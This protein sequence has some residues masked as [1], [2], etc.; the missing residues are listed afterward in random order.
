MSYGLQ[1]TAGRW[2]LCGGWGELRPMTGTWQAME[3]Y[4]SV[5]T[6]PHP[7][8][9]WRVVEMGKGGGK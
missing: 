4:R 7:S 5:A 3:H 1:N 8:E 9:Q 6:L 2:L